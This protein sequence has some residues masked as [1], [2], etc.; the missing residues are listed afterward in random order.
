MLDTVILTIPRGKYRIIE[1]R[2]FSPD[3]SLL[4]YSGHFLVKFV[5]NPTAADKKEKK[6]LPRMTLM[7]RM[8][9]NGV[10]I[11]LKIEFSVAKMLF[12][13]N[14]DEVQEKD[15][16]KVVDNLSKALWSMKVFVSKDDLASAAVSAFHPA[17]NIELT[18]GYTSGFA[19]TELNKIDVSKKLD[20]NRDSFR[21]SGHSLQYYTNSHSLVIYDKVQDLKK[22]DKRAIDKDQNGIQ[23]SLFDI[24]AKKDKREILRIEARLSKKVKMN[25]TLQALGFQANPS[26]RDVF[27][28]EVCQK[29]ILYYWNSVIT[30]KNQFIFDVENNAKKTLEAI[31]KNNPKIKPKQA[32]YLVGLRE[33]SK[34]GIRGTRAIVERYSTGRTWLRVASDLPYLDTISSKSYHGWVKQINDCLS[35]FK[36][37]RLPTL[38]NLLCK[39]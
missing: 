10:E 36:P 29:V 20:L 16:E 26:F 4:G 21:N 30:N 12:G 34:Q 2:R 6:Y 13:N 33:L 38:S 37:Y 14:V 19:I 25:A 23:Q 32:I 5:N 3:A 7:K 1:T 22:P 39:E 28:E 15:F 17:K 35:D 8:T 11:P 31:Y 9:R 27:R 24:V 18:D